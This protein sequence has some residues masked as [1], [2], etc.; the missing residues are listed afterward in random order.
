MKFA[1]SLLM[2]AIASPAFPQSKA[3]DDY[4]IEI[5][6]R[7]DE[8]EKNNVRLEA[9]VPD[10][11]PADRPPV[12]VYLRSIRE[13]EKNMR[14]DACSAKTLAAAKIAVSQDDAKVR[15]VIQNAMDAA[16]HGMAEMYRANSQ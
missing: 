16:K 11:R 1:I 10:L 12:A 6:K 8:L 15:A 13:E 7:A 2:V 9:M 3:L 14:H 5:S 4:C